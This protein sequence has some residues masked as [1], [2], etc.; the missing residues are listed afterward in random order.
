[1]RKRMLYHAGRNPPRVGLHASH[2]LD[3]LSAGR[4]HN[5]HAEPHLLVFESL[6]RCLSRR[7][8]SDLAEYVRMLFHRDR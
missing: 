6:L 8:D 7:G 1:M 4:I 5:T 3:R 2:L